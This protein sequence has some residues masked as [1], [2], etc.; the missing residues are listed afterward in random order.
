[1]KT[2]CY[3]CNNIVKNIDKHLLKCIHDYIN[4]HEYLNDQEKI[5]LIKIVKNYNEYEYKYP[6]DTKT[7][8]HFINMNII[9]GEPIIENIIFLTNFGK[10]PQK[11]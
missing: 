4:N 10:W 2:N 7:F 6:I 5:E 3:L 11:E 9:S 8:I 1:M